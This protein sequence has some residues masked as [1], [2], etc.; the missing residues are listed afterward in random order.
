MLTTDILSLD[1]EIEMEKLGNVWHNKTISKNMIVSY[2]YLFQSF[3][4]FSI[5]F[6]REK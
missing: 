4:F 1:M 5:I 2:F 3:F 6:F